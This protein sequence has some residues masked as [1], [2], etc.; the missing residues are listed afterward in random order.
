MIKVTCHPVHK[1]RGP[2]K[3]YNATLSYGGD[4]IKKIESKKECEFEF[5]DLSYSTTYEVAVCI[6]LLFV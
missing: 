1:F 3:L 4:V 2:E 5:K 6:I